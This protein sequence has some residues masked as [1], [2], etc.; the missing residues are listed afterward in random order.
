M[1][2]E[3]YGDKRTLK[4]GLRTHC[5]NAHGEDVRRSSES[6]HRYNKSYL[7]GVLITIFILGTEALIA[8]GHINEE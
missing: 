3:I 8:S 6:K 2:I 5:D 7:K 1:W 4:T